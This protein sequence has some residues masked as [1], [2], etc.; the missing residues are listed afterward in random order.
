MY[1]KESEMYPDIRRWLAGLLKSKYP[2]AQI[3]AEITAEKKL[4]RWL[5]EKDLSDYFPEYMMYEIDVDITGVIILDNKAELAFV[6]CKL[7]KITL[8][9][10]SQL[11]GYSKVAI[12][13]HSIILS[14]NTLSDSLNLLLNVNRRNDI[15][16][17][18]QDRHI[19]MGRWEESRKD[20]D[21]T[22]IVPIGAFIR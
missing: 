12:P 9:D 17:Y 21:M 6:E 18:A 10:L 22:S 2:K 15:L 4:S 5:I 7:N 14:P 16:Y 19:I 11:M 1:R 13:L 3:I 20:L 8:K